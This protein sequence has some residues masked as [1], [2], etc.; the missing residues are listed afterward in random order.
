MEKTQE[1]EQ[2]DLF[3]LIRRCWKAFKTLWILVL[4]LSLAAG[5]FMYV[6]G[7]NSFY[8]YYESRALFSVTS[9]YGKDDVF[10]TSQF[11]D[12]AAA[13]S[14]VDTFPYL[15]STDIMRDLVV[16]RLSKGYINGSIYASNVAE[17]NLFELRVTSYNP[18]DAYEILCA[19]IECYPQVAVY[20]VDNPQLIIREAP[21]VP[22]TPVNR[23]TGRGALAKGLLLGLV[24]G[25]GLVLLK[26]LLTKTVLTEKDLQ[27]LVNM[28]LMVTV[29]HVTLRRNRQTTRPFITAEDAPGLDEAFRGLR[30]KS[31]KLLEDC[32]G[33]ILLLTSTMPGEGKSTICANLAL[34]LASEGHRVVLLDADLRNQTIFRMFG[35][36][37][38]GKNIIDLLRK[39]EENLKQFVTPVPGTLMSYISGNSTRKRHYTIDAKATRRLMDALAAN[40]DYVIVDSPPCGVVSDTAVFCRYADCVLYVVRQDHAAETQILDAVESL[41][42]RD[43]NLM[44]C[45]MNDVPVRHVRYGYGYGYGYGK[46]YGYGYGYGYGKKSRKHKHHSS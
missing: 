13:E 22:T 45:I 33:K 29:P 34:S 4:V 5:G 7:R 38:T 42:Q 30:V 3:D 16:S 20:M 24:A 19:V 12:A 46:G 6:R 31:R 17:T 1:M 27:K 2:L 10:T 18:E 44:G 36:G 43:V 14:L 35:S 15:L 40:F 37:R 39:P 21:T 32:N 8:P 11:Y 41:Y 28:P 25:M 9:G 23:F 26:A